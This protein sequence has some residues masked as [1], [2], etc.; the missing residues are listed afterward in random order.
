MWYKAT[1]PR[2]SIPVAVVVA[3]LALAPAASAEWFGDAYLGPALTTGSKLT[4]TTFGEERKQNLSGR[5]SAEFGL[6]F[7]R[8]LDEVPWL[9][10][11]AD[12]SYFRPAPDVQTVPISL[13]V[14][15]RYGLL[16]DEEFTRGR[17]QPYVGVGPSLF[18]NNVSGSIGFQESNDTSTDIGL[19]LR[20][21]AAFLIETNW[22][23]FIEYR[24]THVSPTWDVKV[25]GGSVPA[26]TTFDTHHVIFGMGYRF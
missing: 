13:L 3:I 11:A 25:F 14:M 24:F 18:I 2:S 12:V 10:I 23:A 19:D 8:W 26:S 16:K 5:S 6:R 9:A 22:S 20:L 4:F 15:A 21:G 7:G 17:L 1:M